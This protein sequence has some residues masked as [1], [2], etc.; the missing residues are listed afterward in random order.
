M[1]Y[2]RDLQP[3]LRPLLGESR[4]QSASDSRRVPEDQTATVYRIGIYVS[5]LVG[6]A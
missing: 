5:S 4:G 6:T 3:K 2:A 1:P